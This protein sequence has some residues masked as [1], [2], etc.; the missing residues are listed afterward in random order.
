MSS[1]ALQK[2]RAETLS[3][4]TNEP[5]YRILF[6]I[7]LCHLLNDS[8]QSVVTAMFPILEKEMNLSYTQMGF[9]VF[10]LNI[11]SSLMQPVIGIVSDKKPMPYALPAGLTF[12]FIGMIGLSVTDSY[13]GIIG[14]VL[15]LGIGSAT[16]H[17]EGSRVVYMA[18]GNK[19]G[20]AQSIFQVGGN[21]GQALAP[22]MAAFI[23]LPLGLEKGTFIFAFV[24]L[25]AVIFL[26]FVSRWYASQL[27]SNNLNLKKNAASRHNSAIDKR[28]GWVLV[29]LLL[30]IFTRTWYLQAI[31][32]FYTLYSIEV[33]DFQI[34]TSQIYLFAFL[35]AGALGTFFG[36]PLAD[37]FG[38]KNIISASIIMT[39]PLALLLPHVDP[40]FAFILLV[41]IGFILMTSFSVTVVYAQELVP[42]RIGLM[43]GLT[44]G[45]AFG[46]GAIGSV[47]L[48][49]IADMIGLEMM[50][51]S[52]SFLPILGLITFLL[53][54]NE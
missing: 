40:V 19:R 29:I 32:N 4:S 2:K 38:K 49:N 26:V 41:F 43:S 39:I 54:K 51:I 16:F 13:L 24:A 52:I 50:M 10:S 15:L 9:I 45:L 17:P 42:G 30:F 22:L 11:V 18:A 7:S 1:F 31:S 6:L 53:P 33:Y 34:K 27:S 44:V 8:L 47:A 5:V 46:L 20:T 28:V 21:T 37:R 36:G 3:K 12:S 25:T 35:G 48:G 14:S 23:L